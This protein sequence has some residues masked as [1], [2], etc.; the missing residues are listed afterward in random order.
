MDYGFG[1]PMQKMSAL[2]FTLYIPRPGERQYNSVS[3]DCP[4][5]AAADEIFEAPKKTNTQNDAWTFDTRDK[6]TQ[7]FHFAI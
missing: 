5:L 1:C 4:V 6:Q 7:E 3:A 2:I